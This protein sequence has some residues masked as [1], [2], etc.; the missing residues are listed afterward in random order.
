MIVF[1]SDPANENMEYE[2]KVDIAELIK[3]NEV[4]D[5]HGLGPNGA[6]VYCIE[7]LEANVG[8]LVRKILNLKDH[9]II[10]DCPGQVNIIARFLLCFVEQS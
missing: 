8:W 1:C 10:I 3:H 7:F 9:Y 4:M 5:V 6:L 2:A